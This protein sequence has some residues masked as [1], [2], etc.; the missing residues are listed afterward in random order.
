MKAAELKKLLRDIPDDMELVVGN[1]DC[2]Q[3]WN[4]TTN[5]KHLFA[6]RQVKEDWAECELQ[7]VNFFALFKQAPHHANENLTDVA[8]LVKLRALSL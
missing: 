5:Q 1:L 4:L 6:D 2:G 7:Q 3:F 8:C